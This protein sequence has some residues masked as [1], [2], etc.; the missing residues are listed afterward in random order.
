MPLLEPTAGGVLAF[1]LGQTIVLGGAAGGAALPGLLAATCIGFGDGTG[2]A[3]TAEAGPE[4]A[5][6]WVDGAGIGCAVAILAGAAGA[7]DFGRPGTGATGGGTAVTPCDGA[8][9]AVIA[10]A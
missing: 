6:G 8:A 10:T 7:G 3:G 4:A 9:G 1:G 2:F 5:I